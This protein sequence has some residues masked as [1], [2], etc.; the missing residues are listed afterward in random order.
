MSWSL[1]CAAVGKALIHLALVNPSHGTSKAAVERAVLE[2]AGGKLKSI[3][4]HAYAY[5]T[6]N[7]FFRASEAFS[8]CV[9]PVLQANLVL[10][11]VFC[12][13]RMRALSGLQ[14]C[15]LAFAG[16]AV[17]PVV[18]LL[19]SLANVNAK[20][21]HST[22]TGPSRYKHS[23][24]HVPLDPGV[25]DTEEQL[26]H[27][28][29]G[30]KSHLVRHGAHR[31]KDLVRDFLADERASRAT[32]DYGLIP[33]SMHKEAKPPSD[34]YTRGIVIC[35]NALGNAQIRAAFAAARR[36]VDE[37]LKALFIEL[38]SHWLISSSPATELAKAEPAHLR[39]AHDVLCLCESSCDH[40]RA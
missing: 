12:L 20:D 22:L 8:G 34:C 29:G 24:A 37:E 17:D 14:R 27:W 33:R 6:R 32:A 23:L 18:S 11:R 15:V 30:R 2:A 31:P 21:A 13:P 7:V 4:D 1:L 36:R 40:D 16:Y 25:E 9:Q 28:V 19:L 10:A 26:E 3:D 39:A 5:H 35:G 38:P